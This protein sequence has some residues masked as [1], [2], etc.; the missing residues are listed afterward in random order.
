MGNPEA[1]ETEITD[2]A[3]NANIHE[4]VTTLPDRYK[5]I[6]GEIEEI[7]RIRYMTSHPIDMKDS[8]INA[9]ADNSKL[10]PFLHLPIQS[11]SDKILKL[12]NRKHDI[13]FYYSIIEKLKKINPNIGF[14][15]DFIIGYPGEDD[16]DFKKTLDLVKKI[17]EKFKLEM[18]ELGYID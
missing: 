17:E 1:S 4:F 15:S 11:G 18:K 13:K 8:L 14:S 10:M 9:H 6:I 2:A 12:M 5:T 7:K 3:K 16:E